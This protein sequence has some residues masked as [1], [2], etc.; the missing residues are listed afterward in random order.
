MVGAKLLP[1][2]SKK[3]VDMER[4]TALLVLRETKTNPVCKLMIP[5]TC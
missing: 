4:A 5:V 3:K 2:S 1:H